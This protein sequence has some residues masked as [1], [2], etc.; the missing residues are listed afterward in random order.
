[1]ERDR[2][3][4]VAGRSVGSTNRRRRRSKGVERL[5]RPSTA[6]VL[7]RLGPAARPPLERGTLRLVGRRVVHDHRLQRDVGGLAERAQA[8]QRQF[9]TIE[10]HQHDG[11]QRLV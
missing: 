5:A 6:V 2:F 10:Q 1:V 11:N 4:L 3:A 7:R 8:P 9:G